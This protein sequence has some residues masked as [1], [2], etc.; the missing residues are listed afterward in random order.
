MRRSPTPLEAEALYQKAVKLLARR[1]RSE[2]EL[3]RLLTRS[4]AP[5]AL[6]PALDR[7]REHGYLD[8]RRF[9]Q[10]LALY[11]RDAEKFGAQRARRELRRR[12]IA[13]AV[14]D[15][16]LA[17]IYP[18]RGEAALLRAWLA[19][20]RVNPPE[21]ERAAARLYRRLRLAGF[22]SPEIVTALRR[23][24]IDPEWLEALE[25]EEAADEF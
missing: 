9:A 19:K 22:A 6:P 5:G 11:A 16:A 8:D 13:D 3:R 24:K 17:E 18:A 25:E 14:A 10:S 23:W 4:A 2:S 12:G 1:G 21:D 20:K 15:Q 7:L